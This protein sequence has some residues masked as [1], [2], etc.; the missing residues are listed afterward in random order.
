MVVRSLNGISHSRWLSC[1][2]IFFWSPQASPFFSKSGKITP[3]RKMAICSFCLSVIVFLLRLV[4]VPPN[5]RDRRAQRKRQVGSAG[6]AKR[7]GG[8]GPVSCRP[9][10][11]SPRP[12]ASR[13]WSGKDRLTG[14]GTSVPDSSTNTVVSGVWQACGRKSRCASCA[15]GFPDRREDAAA[16]SASQRDGGYGLGCSLRSAISSTR[17]R[18]QTLG[19][20][21]IHGHGPKAGYHCTLDNAGDA[22]TDSSFPQLAIRLDPRDNTVLCF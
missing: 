14:P 8:A 5:R 21:S 7:Q 3:K 12:H 19:N 4:W 1:C 6:G 15:D 16:G 18:R 20:T 11:G 2:R 13:G 22:P 17:A 9:R 10:W